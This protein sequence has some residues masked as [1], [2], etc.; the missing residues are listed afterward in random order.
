M[1]YDSLF[2]NVFEISEQS[3]PQRKV[4]QRM[5]VTEILPVGG[6]IGILCTKGRKMVNCL[7]LAL[8][9]ITS[10]LLCHRIVCERLANPQIHEITWFNG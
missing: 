4:W 6:G 2:N 7:S 10:I 8:K 1:Y 9:L 3:T 5:K